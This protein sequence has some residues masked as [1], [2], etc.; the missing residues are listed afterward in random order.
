MRIPRKLMFVTLLAGILMFAGACRRNEVKVEFK[1][2]AAVS[3]AYSMVYYASDKDKGW[4][5]ETV[6]AVQGGKAEMLLPT[7]YPTIV[8]FTGTGSTPRC[9]FY[10]ERGDQIKITGDNGDPWTW[11]VSGNKLS[12]AWSDW[13]IANSKV[14]KDG[15]YK[16][17]NAVVTK[18]VRE[19][20]DKPLSTLLLLVYYDRRSDEAGFRK[21]WEMLEGDAL[22]P[23]W[24]RLLSRADLLDDSPQFGDKVDQM[25]VSSLGNGVDTIH[26]KGKPLMI[27]FWREEDEGKGEFLE[28]FRKTAVEFGDSDKRLMADISF[29][30]DSSGWVYRIRRD[31][32][33][34]SIRGW[35]YRGEADSV[36]RRMSIPGTPWFVVGDSKGKFLYEGPESLKA[37]S[38]FRSLMK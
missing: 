32:V 36:V 12:E 3:D 23:K 18:F 14:L 17:K 34:K 10:A 19:N 24:I 2:P 26:F 28:R 30:P 9:A 31:T 1:L 35:I 22:Q 16:A 29:D 25:I 21:T 20:P 15:D 33:K 7:R 5:V 37:D 27:Y 11:R 38:I 6:G 8:F 4:Y 13:R